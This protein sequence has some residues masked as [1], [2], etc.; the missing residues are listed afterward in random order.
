MLLNNRIEKLNIFCTFVFAKIQKRVRTIISIRHENTGLP[1]SVPWLGRKRLQPRSEM[2]SREIN[3]LTPICSAGRAASEKPLVREFLPK[4]SIVSIL[5]QNTK[6][7]T[8]VN[9]VWRST[10]SARIIFTSWT[11]RPITRWMIS[12]T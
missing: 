7:A 9:R 8:N 6:P 1:H 3:W 12:A 4:P 10:S 2:L 11:P 5:H